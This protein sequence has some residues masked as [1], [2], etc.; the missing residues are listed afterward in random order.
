MKEK[1]TELTTLVDEL[2]QTGDTAY[3]EGNTYHIANCETD[4]ID[5]A[6]AYA[7]EVLARKGRIV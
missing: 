1:H 7:I 3:I 5:L 4:D 2:N 6:I